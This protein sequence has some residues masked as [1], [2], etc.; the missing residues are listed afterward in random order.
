MFLLKICK[1]F[2]N[3][4]LLPNFGFLQH[5]GMEL[6]ANFWMRRS[7]RVRVA[8]K[9]GSERVRDRAR[10]QCATRT[11]RAQKRIAHQFQLRNH[12]PRARACESAALS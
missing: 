3:K 4:T 7:G 2:D 11:T 1:Q 5:L 6:L 9:R 8:R 10:E 12:W